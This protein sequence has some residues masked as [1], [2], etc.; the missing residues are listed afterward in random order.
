MHGRYGIVSHIVNCEIGLTL[1][2]LAAKIQLLQPL[3]AL[4][5]QGCDTIKLKAHCPHLAQADYCGPKSHQ[6]IAFWVRNTL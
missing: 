4:M 2:L 3:I 1:L 5:V 6:T